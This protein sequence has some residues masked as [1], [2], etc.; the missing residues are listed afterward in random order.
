MAAPRLVPYLGF[1]PRI[2]A[3]ARFGEDATAIGRTAVGEDSAFGDLV[4]LR[5]DG[6]RIEI[7]AGC[8]LMARATVH[9]SDGRL[10]AHI[11]DRATVGRY[12]LVHACVIGD[13]AVLCDGAVTMDG[14]EVGAGAV[15]AAGALVP[16]GKTLE[17][18]VLYAGNPARPVR[19]LAPGECEAF[20]RAVR[21]GRGGAHLDFALPPLSMAPWRGVAGRGA[22]PFHDHGGAEPVAASSAFVAANAALRGRVRLGESV[23]VWYATAV[24]GDCAGVVVGARSNIQ[25]NS[26][27]LA[28]TDGIDIGEDVTVGHNVRMGA[29]R[30]G[31]RALI[32]MGAEVA[33]GVTVEDDAVVGA[34]AFV[35]PGTTVRAGH[36]WAGRP[37]RAF[38]AVSEAER[39]F[40]ARGC[41]VYVNYAARYLAA[42]A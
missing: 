10:S 33:D 24:C 1:R 17:G 31:D 38:R 36:I 11:G 28:G 21:S 4:V 7:G 32:G 8:R 27:L 41:A 2:A 37:A 29:C 20:R 18:D 39:R 9:I 30:V 14:A 6:E 5:G 25:D 15:I 13:G 19:R 35:E 34:R 23:S 3:N 42:A 12:A 26:I 16:P 40:F 22:A